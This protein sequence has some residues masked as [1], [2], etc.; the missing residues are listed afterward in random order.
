MNYVT[1]MPSAPSHSW[2][3][4]LLLSGALISGCGGSAGDDDDSAASD[5]DDSTPQDDIAIAGVWNDG[6]GGV[7]TI[8]NATWS[9]GFGSAFH[10]SQYDNDAQLAIAENDAANSFNPSLWSRFDWHSDTAGM[11]WYCQTCYSCA[12]EAVALATAAADTADPGNAGCGGY[13]WTSLIA[14]Q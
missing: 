14:S 3:F 13:S 1:P 12:D 9:D 4:L 8:T 6:F 10:I 11:L 7:Q 2:L 5:D